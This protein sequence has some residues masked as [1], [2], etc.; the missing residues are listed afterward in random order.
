[1]NPGEKVLLI[2][3]ATP[4]NPAQ[5]LDSFYNTA[6]TDE[7]SNRVRYPYEVQITGATPTVEQLNYTLG[8]PK[9][10]S[11]N[12]DGSPRGF[13]ASTATVAA[14]AYVGI[15]ARVLGNAQVL[16]NA[17]VLD[18][19]VVSN[20]AIVRDNAVVSGYAS[21]RSNATVRDN[22]L[23]T[24][25]AI[26]D[27]GA[28][29]Q[30]SAVVE[31]YAR[32]GDTAII[33]GQAIARGDSY[34]WGGAVLSGYAIADYDY[35]M[36]YNDISDGIQNNHIPFDSYF[37]AYYAQT[38][39]KPRGLIASYRVEETSGEELWDEFGTQQ[40]WLRGS[41]SRPTDSFFN[42][43]RVLGLNGSNQY[44]LLDRT[45]G[46]TT[47]TTYGLWLNPTS[48]A[49]DQTLLYFGSSANTFLKLTARD[50]N[51]FAHLTISVNGTVQQLVSSVSVSLNQWT[52]LAVTIGGGI[53][54]FYINGQA[55]GSAA[56]TFRPIDVLGPDT[57]S[58][59][60]SYYLGRDPSGNYFAGKLEDIRFY[61]ATLTQAEVQNEM[62]RSG[63]KIGQFFATAPT[64]FNG[65]STMMESG[66]HNGT[67]RTL[68]AWIKPAA[69]PDVSSYTPI[70]DSD[71]ERTTS[72]NGSG[73][74]L[75]NGVIKV[76]LDGLGIWN[77]GIAATLNAWQQVAV[78]FNG[79]TATLYV[80]GVQRATRSYTGATPTGKNYRIGYGQTGDATTP[81]LFQRPDLRCQDLR[82]CH[83]AVSVAGRSHC[84]GRYGNGGSWRHVD[85]K[86]LGE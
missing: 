34:L 13:I 44:A 75:D 58:T 41:P 25:H 65:T 53:A 21:V 71:D 73:I 5:D 33:K 6:L 74:G 47:D 67:T 68:V 26:I 83:R 19:A 8:T 70:F 32:L 76:R 49:A 50:A 22:S 85:D 29:V 80:N 20:N 10:A 38:Q 39:T 17:K 43:S 15:N 45:L 1:M 52:H 63:A 66:V 28:Q 59:A 36:N 55:A 51:G 56:M 60:S 9:A 54:K 42:S 23:V 69:S 12:L 78:S 64:T 4:G 24:D 30:A 72:A 61:N 11:T 46:N 27:N 3:V 86:C 40:A 16:G 37:D 18:Y 57:Y 77:T 35:S 62:S 82:F 48:A 31:Q 79:S 14:T 84:G 2:V 81:H 7:S